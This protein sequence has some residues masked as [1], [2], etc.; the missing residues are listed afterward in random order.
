M[1]LQTIITGR[2]IGVVEESNT[3]SNIKVAWLLVFS[4]E[5][6]KVVEFITV[7]KLFLRMKIREAG[8]KEQIQ[9]VL[10][11]VQCGLADVWKK[12]YWKI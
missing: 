7:C 11:Y 2:G 9:W 8:V 5:V 12:T 3:S 10:L 1:G 4:K 6:S